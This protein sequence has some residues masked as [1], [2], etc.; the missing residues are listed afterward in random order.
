MR[1]S[2]RSE[3]Q[4]GCPLGSGSRFQGNRT[5]RPLLL[6]AALQVLRDPQALRHDGQRWIHCQS[7]GDDGGIHNEQ[8][9]M[10]ILAAGSGLEDLAVLVDLSLRLAVAHGT[11]SQSMN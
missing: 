10:D 4:A 6:A 8:P 11:A 2:L 3:A 7:S 1:F 9:A 5:E